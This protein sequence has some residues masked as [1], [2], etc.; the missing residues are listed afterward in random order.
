MQDGAVVKQEKLPGDLIASLVLKGDLS[1]L[2]SEQRVQYYNS[3][4]ERI[5]L[6]PATQP[7]KILNL[8]GKHVLYCDRSGAQQLNR[9]YHVSHAITA[10]EKVEDVFSVYARAILPDGRYTESCGVVTIGNL[11]GDAL[12]NAMM[13]AETKAKRRATLDLLGLGMLDESEIE[14]IPGAQPLPAPTT[15]A[16]V[17]TEE[18]VLT[19]TVPDA[20]PTLPGDFI[21]EFGFHKGKKI[22][23]V[24]DEGLRKTINWCQKNGKYPEFVSK[25]TAYIVSAD[26]K[27]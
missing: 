12:A 6:D 13:K 4:C 2:N 16:T 11:K 24:G 8:S 1:G 17:H 23:D 22:K 20:Q 25:A 3:M 18:A 14:T 10:R 27:I 9:L 26:M 19:E 21:I 5:G 15:V 7:F